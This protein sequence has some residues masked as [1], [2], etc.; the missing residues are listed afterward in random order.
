MVIEQLTN[1]LGAVVACVV[2]D[3]DQSTFGMSLE[4]LPQELAELLS[5]L[6][7]VCHVMRLARPMI[8]GTVDT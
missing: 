1:R 7:R 2:D 6:L 4:Q 5:V 8:Q 3:Q